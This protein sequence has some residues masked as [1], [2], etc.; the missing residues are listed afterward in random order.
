[1][2]QLNIFDSLEDQ[3]GTKTD[4]NRKL[5]KH[6]L[7]NE[8]SDFRIH[9]CY[10]AQHIYVFPTE[11]GFRAVVHAQKSKEQLKSATQP[12]VNHVTSRGYVVPVSRIDEIREILIPHDIYSTCVIAQYDSTSMKGKKALVIVVDML[13][14]NM[15]SLPLQIGI[16]TDKDIQIRGGDITI[17]SKLVL[18]VKCDYKGGSKKHNKQVTGNLY[19]EV[20][21]CNPL[22]RY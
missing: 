18:Q 4:G 22:G 12:G 17:Q 14:S 6:G 8:Q 19:L 15:I 10:L 3:V 21:E 9:V 1:M 20:E 16:V 7:E 11:A 13:K 2:T 5:V